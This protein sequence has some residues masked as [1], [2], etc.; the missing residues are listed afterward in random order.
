MEEVRSINHDL[1]EDAYLEHEY[2]KERAEEIRKVRSMKE[3]DDLYNSYKEKA[4][5]SWVLGYSVLSSSY[6]AAM[7]ELRD[8]W[9]PAASQYKPGDVVSDRL[10]RTEI[11]ATIKRDLYNRG[12]KICSH[13]HRVLAFE[14]FGSN[15]AMPDGLQI[16]CK[17]C[18]AELN[19]ERQ[20]NKKKTKRARKGSKEADRINNELMRQGKRICRKCHLTKDLELFIKRKSGYSDLCRSCEMENRVRDLCNVVYHVDFDSCFYKGNIIKVERKHISFFNNY[21]YDQK[22]RLCE[23]CYKIKDQDEFEEMDY[24]GIRRNRLCNACRGIKSTLEESSTKNPYIAKDVENWREK[25]REGIDKALKEGTKTGNPIG[26]PTAAI[27]DNFG[28]IFESWINQK[29]TTKDA[30]AVVGCSKQA[31]YR[32]CREYDSNRTEQKI[33]SYKDGT[34]IIPDPVEAAKRIDSYMKHENQSRV[35]WI[36]PT[37][38][39]NLSPSLVECPFCSHASQRFV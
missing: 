24:N 33:Q 36:C 25:Q 6:R 38:N 39:R 34:Y 12:Y 20:R 7:G 19:T 14:E 21:L 11:M 2:K 8:I 1:S 31:F 17:K 30:V 9:K 16:N 27:P 3:A 5:E 26:R 23:G 10:F 18:C 28:D 35:G 32:M 29:I 22:L 15:K 13:C 37:C 4:K